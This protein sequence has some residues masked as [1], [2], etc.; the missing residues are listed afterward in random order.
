MRAFWKLVQRDL[1]LFVRQRS[2]II[3]ALLTPMLFWLL[4]GGGLGRSFQEVGGGSND[5]LNYFFPGMLLMSVLFTAIFSTI[6]I[7]EDRAQG[8]LQ[9]VLVSPVSRMTIYFSK[10]CSGTLLGMGQALIILLLAPLAGYS[11]P[12]GNLLPILLLLAVMAA[13]L[14]GL[15][16]LL[17]WKLNSVQGYH[18]MM[19]LLLVP[20]W[21]LSGAVFPIDGSYL[22]FKIIMYVNPLS[23][24]MT[25]LRQAMN[26][27][28]FANSLFVAM[29]VLAVCML[30]FTVTARSLLGRSET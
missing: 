2:R 3:G 19:N 6:S 11:F 12:F 7:V 20:L 23:Y 22:P 14:T 21:M 17:A 26:E 5:Y 24:G 18:S 13:T 1:L 10:V 25:A 4:L 27:V 8:F 29:S 28:A 16:F 9:G 15:G 30:V